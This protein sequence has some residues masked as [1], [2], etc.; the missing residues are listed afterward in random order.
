[1][2]VDAPAFTAIGYRATADF[3]SGRIGEAEWKE[4]ILRE[5]RRF[6]KRQETWFRREADLVPLE[7]DREN[8]PDLV[9]ALARPLFSLSL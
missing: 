4:R 1:V 3:V 6:A 8:L 2:P 5:T 7:A 9:V